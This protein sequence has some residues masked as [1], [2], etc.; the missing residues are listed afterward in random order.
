MFGPDTQLVFDAMQMAGVV[1]A[2]TG[3]VVY[4]LMRKRKTQ[5][6]RDAID[7]AKN[8]DLEERVRV[9]ERIATDRSVDLADEIESL[10]D[11]QKQGSTI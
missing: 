6:N 5:R 2:I 10:R 8:S 11:T 1:A 7:D 4:L 3:G 9:L